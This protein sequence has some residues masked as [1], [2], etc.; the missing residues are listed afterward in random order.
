MGKLRYV[1]YMLELGKSGHTNL[2][3]LRVT[4]TNDM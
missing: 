2:G 4:V 3:F 1:I